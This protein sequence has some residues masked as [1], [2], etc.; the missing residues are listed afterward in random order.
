MLDDAATLVVLAS[1]SSEFLMNFC[2]RGIVFEKVELF[3]TAPLEGIAF[4]DKGYST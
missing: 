3:L 2:Q 1:H 4:H